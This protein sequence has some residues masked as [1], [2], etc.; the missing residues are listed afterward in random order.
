VTER[1]V[2]QVS[3]DLV[4]VVVDYHSASKK[5]RAGVDT[6]SFVLLHRGQKWGDLP[7][8]TH[9]LNLVCEGKKIKK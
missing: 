3:E 6:G 7:G 2:K 5:K 1:L 9:G 4:K 8:H